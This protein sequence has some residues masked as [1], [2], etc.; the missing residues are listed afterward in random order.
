MVFNQDMLRE[1]EIRSLLREE[2]DTALSFAQQSGVASGI[3]FKSWYNEETGDVSMGELGYVLME[4]GAAM[5]E[6]EEYLANAQSR[7]ERFVIIPSEKSGIDSDCEP[8]MIIS[9]II[10][11]EE[12]EEDGCQ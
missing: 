2:R 3:I 8:G 9:D 11:W 5:S 7:E 10:C 12:K 6:L 4:N 1:A